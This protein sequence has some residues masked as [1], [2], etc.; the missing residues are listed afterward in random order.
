MP[1][2]TYGSQWREISFYV[3]SNDGKR[4]IQLAIEHLHFSKVGMSDRF[5]P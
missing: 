2:A 3:M 5:H 4:G 1:F